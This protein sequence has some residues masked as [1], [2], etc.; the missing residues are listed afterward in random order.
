MSI[1][2]L[3]VAARNLSVNLEDDGERVAEILQRVEGMILEYLEREEYGE[4]DPP[5]SRVQQAVLLA[6]TKAYDNPDSD[7]L[8]PDVIALLVPYRS[9]GVF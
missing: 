6:L 5:P 9:P 1:V 3:A 8:T 7:P 4:D 2:D